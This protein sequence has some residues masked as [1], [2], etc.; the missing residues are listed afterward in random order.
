M[1]NLKIYTIKY[2]LKD[3]TFI[4]TKVLQNDAEIY[5]KLPKNAVVIETLVDGDLSQGLDTENAF[6]FPSPPMWW[7]SN[8]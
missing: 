3:K 7:T 8:V 2:K 6:M 1:K 5:D 4:T